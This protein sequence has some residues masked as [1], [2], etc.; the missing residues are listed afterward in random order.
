MPSASAISVSVIPARS[1]SRY[2]SALLRASREHLQRQHDP[3]LPEP[4]LGGQLGEPGPAGGAGPADAEVVVDHPHRAARPAQPRR[5]ARPGRTGGRWTPGC[6]RPGPGWTGGHRRPPARRRCD[7][8]DLRLTHR[9]PPRSR[10]GAAALAITPASNVIAAVTASAGSCSTPVPAAPVAPW[11]GSR[12][13]TELDRLHGSPPCTV[14]SLQPVPAPAARV[15]RQ[16]GDQLARLQQVATATPTSPPTALTVHSRTDRRRSRRPGPAT[17]CHRAAPA[18][19]PRP[20]AAASRPAP[21][22]TG[23]QADAAAA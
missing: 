16:V 18:A 10:L 17:C 22:A 7:G 2:Q 23:P 9:R 5:P 15:R 6:G 8:G 20:R 11:V 19:T 14:T 12:H 21:A 3:D 1:S 4:D 13:Q